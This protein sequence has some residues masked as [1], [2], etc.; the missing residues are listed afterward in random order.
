MTVLDRHAL[1][2]VSFPLA[3]Q[4][5]VQSV[6]ADP[7]SYESG[8]YTLSLKSLSVDCYG[9][10]S[11]RLKIFLDLRRNFTLP[12]SWGF[13]KEPFNKQLLEPPD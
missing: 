7:K 11:V 10:H 13:V 5:P 12:D 9:C 1:K 2:E 4:I 8:M 6:G 3:F